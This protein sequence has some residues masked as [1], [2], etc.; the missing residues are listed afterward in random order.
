MIRRLLVPL[1]V[2]AS[3][4]LVAAPRGSSVDNSYPALQQAGVV[5]SGTVVDGTLTPLAGVALTLERQAVVVSRTTSDSEGRFRFDHVAPGDY[6]VRA[7]HKGAP[8]LLRDLHVPAGATALKLPLV[9]GPA[10]ATDKAEAERASMPTLPPPAAAPPAGPPVPQATINAGAAGLVSRGGRGAGGPGIVQAQ[11]YF[12]SRDRYASVEPNR[13]KATRDEPLSTF[14]AD[15]D[16]ASYANVRR[17]LSS[18]QLPPTDAVRVEELLNYFHPDYAEPR[19]GQPMA[20]TTEVGDCP[21]APSHKLVLVGAQA[22]AATPHA[23]EGRSIVLLIDVSGSMSPA[24]RLPMLKTALG[25]FV[26]TLGRD[27]RIAIVT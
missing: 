10:V 16:T 12:E 4:L 15:V 9:M 26:D 17:F 14:G 24:D 8:A 21:W 6:R 25:L 2:F 23:R 11:P 1:C 5:V 3:L 7:T 18:G 27:D 22:R 13:F 20:L 19:G